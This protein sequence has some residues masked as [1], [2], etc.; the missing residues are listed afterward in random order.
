M[1]KTP[2]SSPPPIPHHPLH[3]SHKH[4]TSKRIITPSCSA[5]D[6]GSP[7]C[8]SSAPLLPA[9]LSS[10]RSSSPQ[11][12]A[13][14]SPRSTRHPKPQHQREQSPPSCSIADA[15]SPEPFYP[16]SHR[17]TITSSRRSAS[18]APAESRSHAS[19]PAASWP[20]ARGCTSQV[21]CA[22][23]RTR[24]WSPT[25]LRPPARSSYHTNVLSVRASE[26]L[27]PAHLSR[28][29]SQIEVLSALRAAEA[30]H[31]RRYTLPPTLNTLLSLRT[32]T[33][34]CP[35]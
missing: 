9:P 23:S 6:A 21:C 7:P 15:P 32:K 8:G 3:L 28:V 29:P 26:R 30:K 14:A 1:N 5:S 31:L 17:P 11:A 2:F 25:P 10:H 27:R 4:Y 20:S 18:R 22:S 33:I 24:T 34:P 12:C 13:A 35:G 16:S 19:W